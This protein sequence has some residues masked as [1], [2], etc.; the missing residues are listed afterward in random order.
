MTGLGRQE[1]PPALCVTKCEV[2]TAHREAK[3]ARGD[4][5]G[6]GTGYDQIRQHFAPTR[7]RARTRPLGAGD[8][9]QPRSKSSRGV[10]A[11]LPNGGEVQSGASTA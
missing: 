1:K 9:N 8:P 2:G 5:V 4:R 6:S 3:R 10:P 7:D 11:D